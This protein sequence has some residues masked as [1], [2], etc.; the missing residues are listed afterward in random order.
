MAETKRLCIYVIYDK[1]K[2]INPYIEPMLR[3]L[4]RFAEDVIV[5]CNFDK[6]VEG[7][8][9]VLPYAT[10]IY[11]RDNIGFDA[12]AYKEALIEFVTWEKALSYDELLLT[13]DTYFAPIYPFDRMFRQMEDTQCDFWGITRHSKVLIE[14]KGEF[15]EHIQS[16]FLNFKREVFHSIHFKHF[17]D[18]YQ[19]TQDKTNTIINF[20]IGI[21]TYLKGE[22]YKGCAYADDYCRPFIN[23]RD[24][25]PYTQFAYELIKEA[26]IP[27]IKRTNFHGRNRWLLNAFAAL[28]YIEKHTDY[29]VSLIKDYISEYQKKGLIGPYYNFEEMEK[30]V[31]AHSNI[32]I[33][34][35]GGWGQITADYFKK[36]GWKYTCFLVTESADTNAS[37]K[38][39]SDVSLAKSDGIIIAQEYKEVCEEIMEYIGERCDRRQLFT[40]CYV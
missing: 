3:E 33:Y 13:N 17:W 15:D 35:C 30:F 28:E 1:Q 31:E 12:G 22:G 24:I 40:P 38:R 7:R 18:A 20:E 9:Y 34:G 4:K 5:V 32:Y 10:E 16:Y 19:Y 2:K 14:G 23:G 8:E 11:F 26:E 37:V 36:K 25:N 27:M 29:D 21:N 6:I 39:F